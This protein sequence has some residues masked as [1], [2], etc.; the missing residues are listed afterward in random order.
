MIRVLQCSPRKARGYV[1]FTVLIGM[2][3]TWL[4]WCTW[5][6]LEALQTEQGTHVA[7]VV[8]TS[9]ASVA[10]PVQASYHYLQRVACETADVVTQASGRGQLAQ[11][12]VSQWHKGASVFIAF[13]DSWDDVYK[14]SAWAWPCQAYFCSRWVGYGAS[15]AQS[16]G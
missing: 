13:T 11:C 7:I 9:A 4:A 8:S 1:L 6:A 15:Q 2:V 5:S 14:S 12:Q 3:I 10:E 16:T